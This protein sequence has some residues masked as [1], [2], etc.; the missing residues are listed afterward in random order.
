MS[1]EAKTWWVELIKQFGVSTAFL[2]GLVIAMYQG[3]KWV[4]VEIIKPV[5]IQHIQF[6]KSTTKS[7]ES[8]ETMTGRI[9][10]SLVNHQGAIEGNQKAIL[11]NQELIRQ[12]NTSNESSNKAIIEA[13][14]KIQENTK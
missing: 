9:A 8:L 10:E 12:G 7:V 13:L 4:A 5:S 3:T 14:K 6:L 2:V 1:D 11:V